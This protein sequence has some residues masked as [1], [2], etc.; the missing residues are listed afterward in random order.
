MMKVVS[1]GI[2]FNFGIPARMLIN[3]EQ[4][5]DLILNLT[6]KLQDTSVPEQLKPDENDFTDQQIAQSTKQEEDQVKD[7]YTK[8]K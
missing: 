8:T 6:E 5:L 7:T 1:S 3:N 4:D 2:L